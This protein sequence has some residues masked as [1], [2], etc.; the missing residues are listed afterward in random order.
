MGPRTRLPAALA[1]ATALLVDATS[2][3]AQTL[4]PEVLDA[5]RRGAETREIPSGH[6][7]VALLGPPELPLVEVTINGTGPYR[8]LVD[9]GSNVVIVRRSV[10]DASGMEVLVE[11]EG[12]DIVRAEAIGLGDGAVVYRGVVMGSYDELDVDG[13]LGYN[14]LRGDDL[15]IDYP[16][17]TL[18]LGPGV[19]AGGAPSM[20]YEVEGRL[21]Y[22]PAQVG[23]R[24]VRLNLDTGATNWIVFPEAWVSWLPL[25]APP[26]DGPMLHN[27]QTGVSRNRIA[28]LAVDLVVGAH[29]IRRPVVFLEPEVD[30]AWLGSALLSDSRIELD[31]R[32]QRVRIMA[33][34]ELR[35]PAYRTVGI[36]LDPARA[37][38]PFRLL[39]DVIPGTPAA[40][41][42]LAVGDTVLR[43]GDVDAAEV[44]W[45]I[46][47]DLAADAETVSLT[48]LHGADT[49]VIPI[50]VA[51]LGA[52]PD[53]R[54]DLPAGLLEELADARSRFSAAYRAH[55]G[56]AVAA[57]YVED[58]RL[59]PPDRT[60]AGREAIERYF[61]PP[62]QLDIL[63]HQMRPAIIW[64]GTDMVVEEGRWSMA[65]R[66]PRSGYVS[67]AAPY[68]LLWR[69]AAAGRWRLTLD[70]WH[71]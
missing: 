38:R 43:V 57:L 33:R 10:V 9:L 60:V 11:R 48:L 14:M 36:S 63:H 45:S 21:P 13:V 26:V 66:S 50:P 61:T 35:A 2:L 52:A 40:D 1:V 25:A 39:D 46:L 18:E 5:V 41:L 68:V 19:F 59:L 58:G 53:V 71:R 16:E 31:T 65:S 70:M 34:G 54:G 15:A 7:R 32:T 37:G 23:E 30:D 69:K 42:P 47:R 44:T 56:A 49:V 29:V 17:R 64:V 4:S 62:A 27:N 51:E 8:F 55:D 67:G 20:E 22:L 3:T 28:Q 12:T 6:A 24:T